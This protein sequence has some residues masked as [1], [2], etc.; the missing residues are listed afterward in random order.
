MTIHKHYR[1]LFSLFCV[2]Y[3]VAWFLKILHKYQ[4]GIY[5]HDSSENFLKLINT[6]LSRQFSARVHM[7]LR[8][9][10]DCHKKIRAFRSFQISHDMSI[11]NQATALHLYVANFVPTEHA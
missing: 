11:I 5:V 7:S 6:S 9:D 1:S 2:G 4:C 8:A 10:I 3:I